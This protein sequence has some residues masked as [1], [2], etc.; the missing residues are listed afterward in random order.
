MSWKELLQMPVLRFCLDA[1]NAEIVEIEDEP[2]IDCPG[3]ADLR[4]R[5]Q[6]MRLQAV[7]VVIDDERFDEMAPAE[8]MAGH[9]CRL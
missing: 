3:L 1:V 8:L 9:F 5:E 6:A 4:R 2:V 7:P